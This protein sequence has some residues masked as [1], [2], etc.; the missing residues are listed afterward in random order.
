MLRSAQSGKIAVL[1]R[2]TADYVALEAA[3]IAA[4]QPQWNVQGVLKTASPCS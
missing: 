3:M 1:I 2:E 4:L